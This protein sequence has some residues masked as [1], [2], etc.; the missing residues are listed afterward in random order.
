MTPLLVD[1]GWSLS[2]VAVAVSIVGGASGIAG[3]FLAGGTVKRF[4]RRLTLLTLLIV[5]VPIMLTLLPLA[6]GVSLG[7]VAVLTIVLL[8]L[9]YAAT[10]TLVYTVA[11]D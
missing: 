4:G 6:L 3:T 8:Q 10:L 2:N 11:M 5:Q 1:T 9:I 7:W